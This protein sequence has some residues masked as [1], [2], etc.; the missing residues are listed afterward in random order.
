MHVPK[1]HNNDMPLSPENYNDTNP[2]IPLMMLLM[3]PS[4]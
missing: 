2:V 4:S 1:I 3:L